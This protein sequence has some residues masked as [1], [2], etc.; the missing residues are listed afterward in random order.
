MENEIRFRSG[1]IKPIECFREGWEAIKP[2]YWILFAISVV[3]LMIGGATMYVLLGAMI[4]GVF[5]CFLQVC[6]GVEPKFEDLFKGFGFW[7]PSLLVLAV[8]ILPTMIV[9]GVVY[10][11]ILLATMMGSRMSE[12][13]LFTMLV[14]TFAVAT[15]E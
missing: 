12:D 3:G 14:G 7:L 9:I 15:V 2:H 8:I 6:D 11:P 10:V 4:C 1:V 5:Y 13:E